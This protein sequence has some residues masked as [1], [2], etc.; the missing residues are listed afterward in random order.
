LLQVSHASPQ[1]SYPI[2][3]MWTVIEE[4]VSVTFAPHVK[5]LL[6]IQGFG[7]FVSLKE[8][9]D[10]DF[11]HIENFVTSGKLLKKLVKTKLNYFYL[12]MKLRV[13]LVLPEVIRN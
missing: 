9:E 8:L 7:N 6:E 12:Q 10:D 2:S 1:E 5:R 13:I 4:A 11:D 3:E